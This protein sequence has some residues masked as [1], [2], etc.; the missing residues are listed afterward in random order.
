MYLP[1]TEHGMRTAG[2]SWEGGRRA[3][4]PHAAPMSNGPSTF[5]L[6]LEEWT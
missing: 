3:S 5:V 1:L 6:D 4:L 2:E